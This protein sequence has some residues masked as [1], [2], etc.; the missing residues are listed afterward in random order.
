M[1]VALEGVL[2]RDDPLPSER[3]L[4][5]GGAIGGA[6]TPAQPALFPRLLSNRDRSAVD[7]LPPGLEQPRGKNTPVPALEEGG[8]CFLAEDESVPEAAPAAPAAV[9]ESDAGNSNGGGD[10]DGDGGRLASPE[11]EVDDLTEKDAE[12]AALTASRSGGRGSLPR[13][14]W[15]RFL[16]RRRDRRRAARDEGMD[17]HDDGSVT[18]LSSAEAAA[19][20]EEEEEE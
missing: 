12:D 19:E 7:L 5:A 15:W 4:P 20:A 2:P 9:A 13:R 14:R 17:G 11:L 8:G 10:G 6:K 18:S 3:V 1:A 16:A